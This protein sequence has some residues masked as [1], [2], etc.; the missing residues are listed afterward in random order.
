MKKIPKS[1]KEHISNAH[2]YLKAANKFPSPTFD[3]VR[4]SLLLTAR[5]NIKIAEEELHAWAQGSKPAK[6][7]YKSHAYK[8]RDVRD[9]YS[10]DRII[11]GKPGTKAKTITYKSGKDFEK[12]Y[13]ICR[14]GLRGDSKQLDLIFKRGWNSDAFERALISKIKW[15]EAAIGMYENLPGYKK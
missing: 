9:S 5:E 3:A 12:L 1:V 15:E 4:I 2:Y 10:I 7:L 13:Q 8:L 14:Y 11:L 6:D